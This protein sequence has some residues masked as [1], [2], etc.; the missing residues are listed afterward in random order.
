MGTNQPTTPTDERTLFYSPEHILITVLAVVKLIVAM[1]IVSL[2][3]YTVLNF[4]RIDVRFTLVATALIMIIG[5][6]YIYFHQQKTYF[7]ITNQRIIL[8]LQEGLFKN[9]S[10]STNLNKIKETAFTVDGLLASLFGYG[11][12]FIHSEAEFVENR[13]ITFKY[14]PNAKEVKLFIDRVRDLVE[15]GKKREELPIYK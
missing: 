11:T 8:S 9:K 15:Q 5:G 12:V 13:L 6:T 2:A 1:V 10:Y 3:T 14:L 4:F 7:Q